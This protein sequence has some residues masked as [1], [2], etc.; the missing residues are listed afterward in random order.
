MLTQDMVQAGT[1][2]C[3]LPAYLKGLEGLWSCEGLALT[4]SAAQEQLF[5]QRAPDA[6]IAN[7]RNIW[8]IANVRNIAGFENI[9][10]QSGTSRIGAWQCV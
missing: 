6:N 3:S 9:P 1:A 8:N 10:E 4:C 2:W 5:W 7:I